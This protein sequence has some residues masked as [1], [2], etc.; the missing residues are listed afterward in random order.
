[1][2]DF[3]Y[4]INN[5]VYVR[6]KAHNFIGDGLDSTTQTGDARLKGLPAK[7]LAPSRGS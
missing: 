7:M 4:A 1:M 5:I 2:G 6:V 3:S